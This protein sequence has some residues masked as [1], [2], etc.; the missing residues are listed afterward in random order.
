MIVKMSLIP[1]FTWIR[2]KENIGG[3][4]YDIVVNMQNEWIFST[5]NLNNVY[6]K[7]KCRGPSILM[8]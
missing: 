3:L 1:V 5:C 6:L 4:T 8:F 7:K 2:C